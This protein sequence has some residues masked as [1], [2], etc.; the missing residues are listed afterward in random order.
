MILAR[1]ARRAPL[2]ALGL[3]ARLLV[4]AALRLVLPHLRA[5]DEV[6]VL[7]LD[8]NIVTPHAGE[9]GFDQ[10]LAIGLADVNVGRPLLAGLRQRAA[11]PAL[12][13]EELAEMRSMSSCIR[14]IACHGEAVKKLDGLLQKSPRA[15][16]RSGC[17]LDRE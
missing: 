11:N 13:A 3:S 4:L 14:R 9:I 6:V 15:R 17:H 1:L 16:P 10:P 8:V 12:L 5:E 7:D 2:L